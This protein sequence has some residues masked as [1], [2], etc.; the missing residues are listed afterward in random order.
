MWKPW[1]D[2]LSGNGTWRG[3]ASVVVTS[4]SGNS[5]AGGDHCN[6]QCRGTRAKRSAQGGSS[7]TLVRLSLKAT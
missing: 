1:S 4:R 6:W 5:G 7:S 3:L 2:D